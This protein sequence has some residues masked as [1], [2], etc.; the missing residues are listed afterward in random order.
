VNQHRR[1]PACAAI[2]RRDR[3]IWMGYVPI[4]FR[5]GKA[6]NVLD[7]DEDYATLETNIGEVLVRAK[8]LRKF[9]F[10]LDLN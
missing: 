8:T 1:K 4:P 2:P 5:R 10:V 6:Y 3:D 7:R 9:F